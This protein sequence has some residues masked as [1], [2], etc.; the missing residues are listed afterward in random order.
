MR[1]LFLIIGVLLTASCST[2]NLNNPRNENLV[3]TGKEYLSSKNYDTRGN[4]QVRFLVLHYT[5][6]NWQRSLQLLRLP[7]YE[8]SSH[9]LI[10]ETNDDSYRKSELDIYQ[11]V[12]ETDRAWHAGK[13]RWEDGENI[14]DQSIGIELV[15]RSKCYYQENNDKLDYKNDYLCIFPDFDPLQIQLLIKLTQDILQRYPAITPTRIIGHA[16]IQPKNKSDPGPQFPWFTLYNNGIGAWYDNETLFPQVMAADYSPQPIPPPLA[17][18]V[19][20]W[21]FMAMVLKSLCVMMMQTFDIIRAVS[22]CILLRGKPTASDRCCTVSTLWALLENI[23]APNHFDMKGRT[24]IVE[25]INFLVTNYGF[26]L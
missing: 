1:I 18:P 21:P 15:N 13:S 2:Q 17:S 10:P 12:D 24:I 11:L 4:S 5:S 14:N 22:K 23:G 25:T 6:S 16:D 20:F 7:E 9:Y 3:N 19:C 8:V 26:D